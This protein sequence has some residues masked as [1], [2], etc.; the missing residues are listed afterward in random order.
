MQNKTGETSAVMVCIAVLATVFAVAV[1]VN[2]KGMPTDEYVS[3]EILF[4]CDGSDIAPFI[5]TGYIDGIYRN[6]GHASVDNAL[7]NPAPSVKVGHPIGYG[8]SGYLI[9]DLDL[10][11]AIELTSTTGLIVQ[12]DIFIKLGDPS[13]HNRF[14]SSD[15]CGNFSDGRDKFDLFDET[16][17]QPGY[18]TYPAGVYA[19]YLLPDILFPAK[20]V[21]HTLTIEK[22]G[23]RAI[24]RIDNTIVK[25]FQRDSMGK[26]ITGMRI[27]FGDVPGPAWFDAAAVAYWDNLYVKAVTLPPPIPATIDIDP[28]T[29]K[30]KHRSEWITAYIELPEGYNVNNIDANTILL[31]STIPLDVEAPTAVGDYDADGI[32]DLMVKFNRAEVIGFI[33]TMDFDEIGR[34]REVTL[35][36]YGTVSG[37]V[38]DGSDTIRLTV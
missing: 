35:T 38:F 15:A 37:E 6:Y 16:L 30:L 33:E 17:S 23:D 29:L 21:W 26:V 5:H 36:V 27:W 18:P 24:Y 4:S 2:V 7:G 11:Q 9:L 12:A 31:N 1:L 32:P 10:P 8:Y 22:F 34:F 20:G 19:P 28:D 3:E 25:I 14:A 13:C